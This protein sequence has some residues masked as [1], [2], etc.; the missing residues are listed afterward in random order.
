MEF[1]IVA[2]GTGDEM[3]RHGC[4]HSQR[5]GMEVVFTSDDPVALAE[6]CWDPTIMQADADETGRSYAASCRGLLWDIAA[7]CAASQL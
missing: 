7:P 5:K 3:H 1:D 2:T 4:K 6:Y